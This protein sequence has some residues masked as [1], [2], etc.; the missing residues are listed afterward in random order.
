ML[1]C[2]TGAS[3]LCH[4][5]TFILCFSHWATIPEI[6]IGVASCH[7]TTF[8]LCFSYSV[9]HSLMEAH[10]LVKSFMLRAPSID[11]KIYKTDQEKEV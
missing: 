8:I 1:W 4:T 2:G 6:V 9:Y 7:T 3:R 10:P 11:D 5:T